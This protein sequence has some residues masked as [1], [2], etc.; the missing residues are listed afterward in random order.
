MVDLLTGT[1]RTYRFSTASDTLGAGV[2]LAEFN[3]V[4]VGGNIKISGVEGLDLCR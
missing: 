1:F 2:K 3:P 4:L